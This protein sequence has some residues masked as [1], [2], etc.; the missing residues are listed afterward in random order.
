MERGK[1]YN[2]SY[3]YESKNGKWVGERFRALFL[4]ISTQHNDKIDKSQKITYIFRMTYSDGTTENIRLHTNT[5]D[6]HTLSYEIVHDPPP[7]NLNNSLMVDEHYFSLSP[8]QKLGPPGTTH[9]M[10]Q[11]LTHG[12]RGGKRGVKRSRRKRGKRL[13]II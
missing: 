2:V 5:N 8:M 9:E 13:F 4:G 7:F 6:L 1:T 3:G 12:K 11:R 10:K